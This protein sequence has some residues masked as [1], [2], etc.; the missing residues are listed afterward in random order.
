[1]IDAKVFNISMAF[2][3]NYLSVHGENG[4]TNLKHD[5]TVTII[6]FR[7]IPSKITFNRP[8]PTPTYGPVVE[9]M[10]FL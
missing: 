9:I 4:G 2:V 1:M 5:F 3:N 8:H 10:T 7:I 6:T